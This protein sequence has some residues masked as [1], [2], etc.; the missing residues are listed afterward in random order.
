MLLYD[1]VVMR[2]LVATA[3]DW[4]VVRSLTVPGCEYICITCYIYTILYYICCGARL[5]VFT[6]AAGRVK[7]DTF[8][9]RRA[10][11]G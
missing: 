5:A 3:H 1:D 10:P 9:A 6:N 7:R 2:V 8:D 11:R 4:A